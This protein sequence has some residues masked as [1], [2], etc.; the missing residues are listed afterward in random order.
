MRVVDGVKHFDT[1]TGPVLGETRITCLAADFKGNC[2]DPDCESCGGPG[3][4]YAAYSH[5]DID[6]TARHLAE[7]HCPPED[8]A[9]ILKAEY[10]EHAPDADA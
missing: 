9:G 1:A 10:G 3:Y 4:M 5:A 7:Q 6:E 2:A 8:M